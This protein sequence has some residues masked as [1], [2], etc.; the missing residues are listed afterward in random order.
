MRSDPA[1]AA[2]IRLL[3]R[4]CWLTRCAL[5]ALLAQMVAGSLHAERSVEALVH[6]LRGDEHFLRRV[7]HEYAPDG[8][9]RF[10][11]L[12]DQL[13]ADLGRLEYA[14]LDTQG[15]VD[16]LLLS[17]LAD[18]ERGHIRH[19]EERLSETAEF[20]P[21]AGDVIAMHEAR[22]L[23]R[24][25]DGAES[26][27]QMSRIRELVGEGRQAFEAFAPD[28]SSEG[29]TN[30]V[31]RAAGPD[32]K[33]RCRMGAQGAHQLRTL[34]R[35]LEHWYRHY[36]TYQ[37]GITWWVETEWEALQK[38][39]DGYVEYLEKV[40]NEC[41]KED[42]GF[43]E[44]IP[45]G[46]ER[47]SEL[48]RNEWIAYSARELIAIG[49]RE[50]AWCRAEMDRVSR[51]LGVGGWTNTMALIK[52]ATVPP[53][54]QGELVA[55]YVS[56]AVEF[57]KQKGLLRIPP[58]CE[59]SWRINMV[60]KDA[61]KTLPYALYAEPEIRV[62]YAA[63]GMEHAEMLMS[64]RGNNRHSTR[65]V[66]AHESIPGHHYE[67]FMS[68]RHRPYRQRFST[69]FF[70]EGWAV[71]WEMR[72]WDEGYARSAED[73]AG[74]LFWRAHRCARVITTLRYHLGEMQAGEMVRFLVEHIGHEEDQ[75]RA[76]VRRYIS[77]EADVLYQVSYLVGAL[78]LRA[79]RQE[80]VGNEKMSEIEFHDAVLAQGP[81][82]VELT[83]AILMDSRPP[84]STG[85]EWR[86][87][88]P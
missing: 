63:R 42:E 30:G 44:S 64:M 81:I 25:A 35:N 71:Y 34:R 23:G 87:A 47:L 17:S 43:L 52:D 8:L 10:S 88:E 33:T 11:A 2:G 36:S 79:L 5:V 37:P 62:A 6:G 14:Q 84:L 22:R 46:D 1:R 76:E 12:Y 77:P 61:Q 55:G 24:V 16:W 75:A 74:M 54:R 68:R 26:S 57:L 39:L 56:E 7:V 60:G 29:A 32:R 28:T 58:L 3:P 9:S 50:L 83:R 20:M 27:R 78:Q 13:E 15:R 59:A 53:G 72:L 86:F 31:D 4:S 18:A 67:R 41:E 38:D 48:L 80:W 66:I 73:R 19:A 69:P 85:P 40:G 45:A 51:E 70:I 65:I 49:E 21:F 82:P